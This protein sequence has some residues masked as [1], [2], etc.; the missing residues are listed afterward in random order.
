MELLAGIH[1]GMGT[2]TEPAV[3]IPSSLLHRARSTNDA[4]LKTKHKR[5]ILPQ[6]GSRCAPESYVI[7]PDGG[8]LTMDNLPP[9]RARRWVARKKAEVVAAVRG[10]L[11]SLD[12]ACER[13]ELSPEEF[14]AWQIALDRF[15]LRGLDATN[16]SNI[17]IR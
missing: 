6:L 11:I 5:E 15:G 7:G 16:Q 14:F 17:R 13:Y 3:A 9:A 10:G 1:P 8:V 12:D 2:F 4:M